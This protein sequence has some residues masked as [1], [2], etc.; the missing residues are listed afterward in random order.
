MQ[1]KIVSIIA[2][3]MVGLMIF[4]LIAMAVPYIV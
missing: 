3:V 4:D 2:G 1:K